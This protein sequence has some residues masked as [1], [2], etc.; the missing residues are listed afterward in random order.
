MSDDAELL[1]RYAERRDETAF[2]E[3]VRRHLGLVYHAAL[4]Q[5][6]GDAHRAEDVAQLVFADLARKAAALARRPV[7]AG[8][9]YTST[10]YAAAQAVRAEARRQRREQEAQRMNETLSSSEP[11]AD[12]EKLRPVIDDVLHTLGARERE[13]V[14]LRFFEGRGFAELGAKF[15]VSEDAARMRVDRALEKMRTALARRGVSSTTAALSL[16]LVGQSAAAVPTGLTTSVTGA[17]LATAGAGGATAVGS[18]F[19]LTK[20]QLGIAGVVL[21][22]GVTG[23]VAQADTN[24][25]LENEAATLRVQNERLAALKSENTQLQREMAEIATLRH[26]DSELTR[27]NDEALALKARFG[28]GNTP[29]PVRAAAAGSG[30]VSIAAGNLTISGPI[31]DLSKLD[32]IPT[33][34]FQATPSYP[35]EMRRAGIHGEV[36]VDF[37]VDTNGAVQNVRAIK[38]SRVDFEAAA[39]QAV[40]K[41]KFTPGEV[42]A[43]RVNA[44]M[45]VPIVFTLTDDSPKPNIWF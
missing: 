38:S 5:C 4:R 20:L 27:L 18:L 40:T 6:G 2:A 39:V 17:A 30:Q 8:W 10:R 9:L 31:Y 26:D 7:L 29:A 13:A 44:H 16:A 22:G 33:V 42:G 1:L 37:V 32:Q 14:L 21:A 3:L 25:R 11:P 24:A 41:W 19:M 34:T 36:I 12:W 15:A 23:Y 45:Q 35:F 28:S 43:Q